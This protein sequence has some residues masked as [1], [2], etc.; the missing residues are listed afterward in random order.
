MP[1]MICGGFY[2]S[3]GDGKMEGKNKCIFCEE[4]R[5]RKS[6]NDFKRNHPE[7][8]GDDA[9][10][11]YEIKVAMVIRHWR[12]GYK[13]QASRTTDYRSQGCGYALNFC[14]ECGRALK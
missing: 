10:L 13:R 7:W 4:Y 5:T 11:Q 14:P 6:V 3:V 8:Y 12:A 1:K 2:N 9:W